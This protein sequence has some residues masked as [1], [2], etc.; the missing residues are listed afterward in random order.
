MD[1]FVREF[2]RFSGAITEEG[3][4]E[5]ALEVTAVVLRDSSESLFPAAEKLK[6][7]GMAV[8]LSFTP[9]SNII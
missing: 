8:Q 4:P 3:E 7:D 5:K 9:I 1:L 2:L 6:L